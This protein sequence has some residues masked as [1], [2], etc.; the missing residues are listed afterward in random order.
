MKH[1][2]SVPAIVFIATAIVLGCGPSG[3]PV[4]TS[5]AQSA[6]YTAPPP[7]PGFVAPNAPP[8]PPAPV[9]SGA[10]LPWVYRP[11]PAVMP[12][13]PLF[14]S[15][16]AVYAASLEATR[17]ANFDSYMSCF[18][19]TGLEYETGMIAFAMQG[20]TK[21]LPRSQATISEILARHSIYLD[22]AQKVFM[23]LTMME[24]DMQRMRFLVTIGRRIAQP[25]QFLVDLDVMNKNLLQ[26]LA[27][28]A[29]VKTTSDIRNFRVE[30]DFAAAERYSLKT[31]KGFPIYFSK[32]GGTWMIDSDPQHPLSDRGSIQRT[33]ASPEEV[34]AAMNN[35]RTTFNAD[36]FIAC[37]TPLAKEEKAGL[38]AFDICDPTSIHPTDT[39]LK[40]SKVF[41]QLNADQIVPMINKAHD[42][43]NFAGGLRNLGKQ[44]RDPEGLIQYSM[45]H[46]SAGLALLVPGL[47]KLPPYEVVKSTV[48]GNQATYV[49]RMNFG[50]K[51]YDSDF[52]FENVGGSWFLAHSP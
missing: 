4:A 19:T 14:E 32:I 38:A 28:G 13:P 43:N 18:T 1:R 31:G 16:E 25:K 34:I 47:K 22:D 29:E 15:P 9:A 52:H 12:Q 46:N 2:I 35:A 7:P 24:G 37:L 45:F 39:W 17:D 21:L 51:W 26:Q 33:F 11:S 41:M 23:G 27:P 8:P 5:P 40:S 49:L 36:A 20:V 3:S 42:S 48:N 10:G 50:K 6:G 30:G 44:L